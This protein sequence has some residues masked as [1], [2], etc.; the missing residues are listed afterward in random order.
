MLESTG[1]V[2]N[3]SKLFMQPQSQKVAAFQIQNLKFKNI[4]K[5]YW[6][7]KYF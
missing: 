7:L 3:F 2:A 5:K 1:V 6:I 4:S